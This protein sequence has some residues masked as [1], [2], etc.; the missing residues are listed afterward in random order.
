MLRTSKI[1]VLAFLFLSGIYAFA[2]KHPI[3]DRLDI[4]EA[5]GK[6][7]VS[8]VISA[9]NTCNGID[10]LRSTDSLNYEPVGH[11]GGVCGS[12]SE[13]VSYIIIDDNPPKNKTLHYKLNL[14]GYGYTESIS[15][16]IIDTR[17][18]GFQIRP[19][20]A[21]EKA[22]IYFE[23]RN[24]GLTYNLSLF[25]NN[26]INISFLS[27]TTNFFEINTLTFP[28]GIYTFIISRDTGE[29]AVSGKLLVIH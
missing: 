6:V 17:E 5:N 19:N 20:P 28:S 14:G 11:V 1:I 7:Y 29:P 26:G 2:Q 13:P 3:L 23:N 16:K 18:F 12:S 8:C 25:D 10:L 24:Q 21:N 4:F 22:T 9:G 27:T 15:I